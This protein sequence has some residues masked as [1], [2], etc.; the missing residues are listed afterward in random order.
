[1]A[2]KLSGHDSMGDEFSFSAESGIVA[3]KTEFTLNVHF[4]AMK[5]NSYKRAVKLEVG[6]AE[7]VGVVRQE[8][9]MYVRTYMLGLITSCSCTNYG[10][11]VAPRYLMWSSTWG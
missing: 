4:R 6:G 11:P 9:Y 10:L 1:M 5:P 7:W 8:R 2:W 3:P